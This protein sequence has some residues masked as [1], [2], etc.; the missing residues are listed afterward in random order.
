MEPDRENM[1]NRMRIHPFNML[2]RTNTNI[3][4]HIDLFSEYDSDNSDIQTSE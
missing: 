2:I 1:E 4:I 3:D